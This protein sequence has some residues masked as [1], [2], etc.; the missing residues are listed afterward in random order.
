MSVVTIVG[1]AF[2]SWI[3]SMFIRSYGWTIKEIGVSYGVLLLICG[4]IGVL[5]G[6][7][8]A[9]TLYARGYKN[10]HLLAA[11]AGTVLTLPFATLM[12]LM[13]TGE[14]AM[15]MLV[16]ASIGP[17]M[18]SATG[19]S[20]L[21]MIIPNQMRAQTAAIYLFVISILGLTIGPTAVAL[22]TDYVFADE[23]ALRYSIAL[24]SFF[25]A[26]L[27]IAVLFATLKPYRDAVEESEQWA[28]SQ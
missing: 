18:S 20:A 27:S 14:W 8:L 17:A 4:P 23:S 7:W 2:F 5:S 6:G 28:E 9:D 26:L 12:P 25:A 19:S 24:V 10:G 3:P 11:L 15:A 22:V 1:Y 13:P 21:V 16:P